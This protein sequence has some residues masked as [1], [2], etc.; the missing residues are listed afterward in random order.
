MMG[1]IPESDLR[2]FETLVLEKVKMRAMTFMHPELISTCRVQA[3]SIMC[4]DMLHAFMEMLI[5]GSKTKR[6]TEFEEVPATWWDHLKQSM[7]FK[8]KTKQISREETHYHVCPHLGMGGP[9]SVHINWLATAGC[10]PRRLRELVG[11]PPKDAEKRE[12]TEEQDWISTSEPPPD[13]TWCWVSAG[14]NVWIAMRDSERCGGWTNK[15]TWEDFDEVV[16]FYI[17]IAKPTSPHGRPF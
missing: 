7:G 4:E 16:R 13:G 1:R 2:D 6:V 8:H 3:T 11:P 15:D 14:K 12:E 5:P 9:K 10:E 17:P